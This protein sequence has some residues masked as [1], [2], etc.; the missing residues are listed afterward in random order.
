MVKICAKNKMSFT[1]TD[2]GWGAGISSYYKSAKKHN[3]K[4]VFGIEFYLSRQRTRLFEI[5]K[6]LQELK[7]INPET[8]EQKANIDDEIRILN[9]EFDEIKKYN[10]LVILVKNKLGLQNLLQLHNQASLNGFYG[11]PLITLDE[12]FSL[13]KDKNGDRGLIVTSSCLSGV[14]PKDLLNDKYNNALEHSNIMQEEF[15]D[16]WY[17]EIQAHE[18]AE[19]RLV[20]KGI[21]EL[22]KESNV[23]III[24]TD[25]HYLS[26]DF[27]RSHEI[28]LLLQGEQKV[29]DIGKKVLQVTYETPR[30]ETRRKKIN[31]ED[32]LFFSVTVDKIKVG[33]RIHKKNGI[34]NDSQK[35]DFEVKK[36]SETNKVW[37]IESADLSFKNEIQLKE[38]ASQYE[39]LLPIIDIAIENNKN[40]YEKIEHWDWDDDLKLPLYEN[41]DTELFNK[42]LQALKDKNLDK[43]K[44]YINRFKDEFKAIKNGGLCSYIILLL[45]I[46]EIAWNKQICVGPGR[47]SA[48][49]SLIFYLLNI[50]RIDP[51]EWNFQFERF[52]NDKKTAT[53]SEKIRIELADGR[54]LDF[55]PKEIIKLKN[56]QEI[57]ASKI[58]D[59]MELNL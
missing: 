39:E 43:N 37:M 10:H 40:I 48:S 54:V 53:D 21:L 32:N 28:F 8:K 9:Y 56:G 33:D 24:G 44:I 34:V 51:I 31:E 18:L 45:E 11:K 6:K 26:K 15:Q 30:G 3:I 16:N 7:D 14:I 38:H 23:P 52:I 19:Q 55:L 59:G 1:L 2:H 49:A 46:L 5:R 50:T 29:A 35:W 17:L 42:C 4:P 36:I 12:L 22:S 57:E 58:I 25:S 41:S 20:N 27:S 13:E 47:G